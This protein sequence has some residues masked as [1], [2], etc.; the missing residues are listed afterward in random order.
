MIIELTII[1][2]LSS[3]LVFVLISYIHFFNFKKRHIRALQSGCEKVYTRYGL[4][5]YKEEGEGIAVLTSHGGAGGYDQGIIIGRNHLT[6]NYRIISPSRFGHLGTPLRKNSSAIAQADAYAEL[7]D[8]LNIDKVFI[9][10]SSG[11]GPSA[12]QFAMRYPEKCLGLILSAAVS[13]YIPQRSKF[14]YKSSYVFWLINKLALPIALAKIGV[15]KDIQNKLNV[16]EKAYLRSMLQAIHP[17]SLRRD[18][19]FNDINEWANKDRWR[20]FYD[21]SEISVPTLL[22]HALNDEVVPYSMAYNL[23][24][25]ISHAKLITLQNGGHLRL[26]KSKK[27]KKEVQKFIECSKSGCL[28]ETV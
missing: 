28:K 17:I 12:I 3:I 21:S 20:L 10:G 16:D 11:G 9:I 14:V 27:I 13:G 1:I 4:I 24:S 23:A 5:E 25:K 19:L 15:T 6:K 7:L 26:G 18:G 22:I 8:K 2:F